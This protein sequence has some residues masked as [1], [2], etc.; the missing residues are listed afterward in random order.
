MT[1][2]TSVLPKDVFKMGNMARICGM[3]QKVL[4]PENT[5]D[6]GYL[7]PNCN[8][9]TANAPWISVKIRLPEIGQQVLVFD[10]GCAGYY[11]TGIQSGKYTG[12]EDPWQVTH[13]CESS[14]YYKVTHWMPLPNP[15]EKE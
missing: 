6:L 8:D 15:P 3:C 11:E 13:F 2:K 7:Q 1:V 12:K 10:H 4:T 14:Y 5:G 9:C